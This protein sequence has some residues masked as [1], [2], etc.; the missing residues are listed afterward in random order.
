MIPPINVADVTDA[1]CTGA[2]RVFGVCT[3]LGCLDP[4][5]FAATTNRNI[6]ESPTFSPVPLASLAKMPRL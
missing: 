2:C 6:A 4:L 5:A 1:C 3:G